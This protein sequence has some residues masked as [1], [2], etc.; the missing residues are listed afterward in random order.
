MVEERGID[1]T[2][3]LSL[4]YED[5]DIVV[6]TAPNEDELKDLLMDL[7]RTKGPM[8]IRELH[9]HLSGL[10]SED[11]IRQAL[12]KLALDNKVVVTADGRYYPAEAAP[13]DEEYYAYEE[14]GYSDYEG[15]Y[16]Y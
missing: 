6:Y 4:V 5:S 10:A 12:N 3:K 7:L 14:Y 8:T 13:L 9:S 15:Y 1:I 16:E 11:K 2:S